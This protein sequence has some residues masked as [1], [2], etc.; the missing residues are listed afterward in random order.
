MLALISPAKTLDLSPCF[1]GLPGSRPEF[2][3]DAWELVG[4]LK[5]FNELALGKLL[6]I[7]P[8]LAKLNVTRLQDFVSDADQTPSGKYA[9][10]MYRGD[11]YEGLQVDRWDVEDWRFSQESLRIVSALYGL[12]RPL[13][14]IQPYRLEMSTRLVNARGKDLYLFWGE[15]LAEAI[16]IQAASH[17]DPTVINLASEAYSKAMRG[18]KMLT[19]SFKEQRSG[20]LKVIGLMAKRARGA[21]ARFMIQ[22]RLTTPEGLQT[23]AEGGYRFRPELSTADQWVF[24][25]ESEPH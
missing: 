24:V 25:R 12:L 1:P 8:A 5:G 11:T 17:P 22:N 4:Q 18:L 10:A 3:K 2:L 13:D 14:V 19:V 9:A 21:M 16:R 23:F 20:Q 6:G 15:R 7:S